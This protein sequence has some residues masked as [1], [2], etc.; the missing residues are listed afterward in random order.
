MKLPEDD[1]ILLS[2]INTKLRDAYSSLAEFCEDCGAEEGEI[3]SRLGALG[4][5][6]DEEENAFKR[7]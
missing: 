5:K 6:Y 1:F 4:Y 2:Y 3:I 7:S